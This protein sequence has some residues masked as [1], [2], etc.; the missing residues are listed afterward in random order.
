MDSVVVII[1]IIGLGYLVSMSIF[2]ELIRKE[3]KIKITDHIISII[4]GFILA[5]ILSSL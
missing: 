1:L 3:D 5:L 4:V 2:Q